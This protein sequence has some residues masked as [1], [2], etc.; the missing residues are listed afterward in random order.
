[1]MTA[2]AFTVINVSVGIWPPAD[3]VVHDITGTAAT[4]QRRSD[5]QVIPIAVLMAECHV[6]GTQRTVPVPPSRADEDQL[7][8]IVACLM[9]IG[10]HV[11]GD[12]FPDLVRRHGDPNDDHGSGIREL[13]AYT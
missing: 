2:H 5:G 7:A 6:I 8:H 4:A 1:M 3:L 11:F 9:D 12:E 10:V 13:G